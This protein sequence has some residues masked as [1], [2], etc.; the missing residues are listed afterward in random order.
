MGAAPDF[1]DL[2]AS[3][4][5][6]PEYLSPLT[7]MTFIPGAS[8]QSGRKAGAEGLAVPQHVGDRAGIV[9]RV[10]REA[11]RAHQVPALPDF[12]TRLE[13]VR[14]IGRTSCRERG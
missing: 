11:D 14:Q 6:T 1:A 5:N 10:D 3:F 4:R 8:L 7:A 2:M 13:D 12:F 9:A